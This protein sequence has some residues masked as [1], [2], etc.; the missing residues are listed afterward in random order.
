M[1]TELRIALLVYTEANELSNTLHKGQVK[2]NR[3]RL[4]AP[5]GVSIAC[6]RELR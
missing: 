5:S 6:D 1:E 4:V 2:R 3:N